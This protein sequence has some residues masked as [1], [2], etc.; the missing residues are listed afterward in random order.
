MVQLQDLETG[1]ATLSSSTEGEDGKVNYRVMSKTTFLI[2]CKYS[3]NIFQLS[4]A[5]SEEEE[6]ISTLCDTMRRQIIS[7]WAKITK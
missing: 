3:L 5:P 7:R 1:A 4:S 6:P 2:I